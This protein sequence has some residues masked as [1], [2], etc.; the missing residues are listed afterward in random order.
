MSTVIPPPPPA[1][2]A[3]APAPLPSAI[4]VQPPA[5][6]SSL[7]IGAR[8][9]AL[10]TGLDARG[11]VLVETSVGRLALQ[12]NIS[13]PANGPIQLQLQS[14]G[15]Q[16]LLLITGIDGKPPAQALR[17]LTTA[18]PATLTAAQPSGS[19]TAQGT[20]ASG[21][22]AAIN[23]PNIAPGAGTAVTP[24][25][26]VNLTVGSTLGATLLQPATVQFGAAASPTSGPS[27]GGIPATTGQAAASP[28][29]AAGTA[30]TPTSP[31]TNIIV[32]AGSTMQVKVISVQ[33][34]GTAQPSAPTGQPLSL[35]MRL[36]GTVASSPTPHQAIVNTQAGPVAVAIANPPPAGS[37]LTFEITQL[38]RA[39]AT[40]IDHA[41]IQRLGQVIAE[42][43]QW[44]VLEEAF[45]TLL[46]SHPAT[47]Q[48][49]A[50][51]V[52][53]RADS[54]LSTN[55]LFFL[56]ALRGGNVLNWLGDAP[57]R[58]LERLK[59]ALLGRLRDDFAGL[60]RL[61]DEPTGPDGRT[62]PIPFANGQE[63]EQLR[64][65]IRRREEDQEDEED[66]RQGPGTRF[67]VDV[68]LTKL[69]RMQLD[70]F[71][72][73][74]TKRFDLIV[75]SD[76]RLPLNVQNGIRDIFEGANEISGNGGGL[77]FQAAP[78]NFVETTGNTEGDSG[79][80]FVV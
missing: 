51:A 12:T 79:L 50:N 3:V 9:E 27:S 71:V 17:A 37:L 62:L 56:F 36:T 28:A 76:R 18:L 52:L 34:P 2:P 66:E 5:A 54:S 47:A 74:G 22:G 46:E 44:P 73:D 26:P 63:I 45:K 30:A 7:D 25:V 8:L 57:A 23:T 38:P 40:P 10:V 41:V 61:A 59:P 49:L 15:N 24:A 42:T 64:L 72:Q 77:T 48:Q 67:V 21:A 1:P 65:L 68:D 13:L 70:G 11:Q 14:V 20:P 55:L 33:P 4:V 19:G 75:R 69:G 32:P 16:V 35:A 29:P 58:A 6:L 53:P 31:G 78:P 43:R 39:Q 60:S 80:G